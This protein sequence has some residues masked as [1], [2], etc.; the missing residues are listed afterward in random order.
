MT[1][2]NT[3]LSD[4]TPVAQTAFFDEADFD[5]AAL[6]AEEEWPDDLDLTAWLGYEEPPILLVDTDPERAVARQ[7]EM[8]DYCFGGIG[9]ERK[10]EKRMGLA[11]LFLASE[12]LTI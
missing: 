2:L 5:E 1:T 4:S 9:E 10:P 12:K 11:M 6:L 3:N 8:M 7:K